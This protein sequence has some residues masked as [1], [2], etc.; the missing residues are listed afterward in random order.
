MAN[1]KLKTGE[2]WIVLNNFPG[3]KMLWAL[4]T[5][6]QDREVRDE[7]YRRM[8]VTDAL[9][10]L[11][12]RYPAATVGEDWRRIA[13]QVDKEASIAKK[14]VDEII[15]NSQRINTVS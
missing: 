14:L 1:Y 13:D 2:R 10:M 7:M 15:M 11:A 5:V 8:S 6:A 9:T 3:S 12:N 4:T